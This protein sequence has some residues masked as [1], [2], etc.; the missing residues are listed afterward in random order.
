MKKCTF[1]PK[2]NNDFCGTRKSVSPIKNYDKVV[3][4]M[5]KGRK[6]KEEKKKALEN[7]GKVK[8]ASHWKS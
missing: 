3:K 8:N 4:R 6:I 1:T 5:E 2:I 7:L